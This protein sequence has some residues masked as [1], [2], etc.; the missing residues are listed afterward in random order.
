MGKV[1]S[2]I[3]A[4]ATLDFHRQDIAGGERRAVV[5]QRFV[6]QADF[7]AALQ[8]GKLELVGENLAQLGAN[9]HRHVCLRQCAAGAGAYFHRADGLHR[10]GLRGVGTGLP[11][12][13]HL[14]DGYQY[15]FAVFVV[16]QKAQAKQLALIVQ[17][18]RQR[19]AGF[20]L[21]QILGQRAGVDEARGIAVPHAEAVQQAGNGIATLHSLIAPVAHIVAGNLLQ[22]RQAQRLHHMLLH[23]RLDVR[24]V[25]L[26]NGHG[27]KHAHERQAGDGAQP[28]GMAVHH[29]V[30]PFLR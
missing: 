17:L 29:A 27:S 21:E 18:Y 11:A 3:V 10:F 26:G 19:C 22:R 20:Q 30:T 16:V 9:L 25:A 4:A 14:F 5:E 13:A 12:V 24:A 7:V 8:A 6:H 28:G 1:I 23:R 2:L 15:A